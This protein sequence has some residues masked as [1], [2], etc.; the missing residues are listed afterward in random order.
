MCGQSARRHTSSDP[1]V[2][3]PMP[4]CPPDGLAW[5]PVCVGHLAEV[6]GLL[7]EVAASLAAY[8]PALGAL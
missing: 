3:N 2:I 5:C 6:L 4:S 1:M 8:D 7:G